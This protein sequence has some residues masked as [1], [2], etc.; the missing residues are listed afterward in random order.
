VAEWAANPVQWLVL[1]YTL[2]PEPTRKRAYVWREL[3]KIGAVYLRDGVCVLPDRPATRQALQSV[4]DRV[5]AFEGQATLV[6]AALVDDLTVEEVVRQARA[7]RQTEYAALAE[8][9]RELLDHV[10]RELRH[11]DFS[12][13]ETRTLLQDVG[14]LWRWYD[15]IC[16][17]DYFASVG[18]AKA[19]AAIAECESTIQ[20]TPFGVAAR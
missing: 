12:E 9:S 19:S 13:V 15:Q 1:I 14:K 17:R 2:P 5:R 4:V 7:A 11:R 10:H 20:D 18:A 3:K 16:A 6:E 8:S